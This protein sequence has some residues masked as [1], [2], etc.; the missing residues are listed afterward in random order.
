MDSDKIWIASFDIGSVNFAFYIEEISLSKIRN[1]ENIPKMHRYKQ[2]GTPTEKMS[3]LLNNIYKNGKCILHI[4]SS[5]K[6]DVPKTSKNIVHPNLFYNMNALL[7]KYSEYW[8]KCAFFVIERQMKYCKITKIG[9]HCM[10]YFL[11]TYGIFKKVIDFPSYNKTQVLGAQKTKG[12]KKKKGGF[13]WKTMDKPNRKK[14]SVNLAESILKKRGELKALENITTK[15]KK[16]DLADTLT[17]LQAFK[18]L[19]FVD[20]SI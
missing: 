6:F 14:W 17:Q 16:D 13:M 20:K 7:D 11:I 18:Y 15:R 19:H 8:D 10:S 2:D 1:L 4:N 3:I 5:L 12:R 9:Q